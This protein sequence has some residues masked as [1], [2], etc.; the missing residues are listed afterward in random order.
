MLLLLLACTK[1]E[2]VD[3]VPA[4]IDYDLIVSEERPTK[5]SEVY[6]IARIDNELSTPYN[7]AKYFVTE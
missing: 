4:V 1:D 7:K 2:G 6:G 5:R 3:T